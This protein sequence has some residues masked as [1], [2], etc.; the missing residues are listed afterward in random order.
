MAYNTSDPAHEKYAIGLPIAAKPISRGTLRAWSNYFCF[1]NAS[2]SHE[3]SCS[4]PALS[5]SQSY[6]R[7]NDRGVRTPLLSVELVK[8]HQATLAET[9]DLE[10][11]NENK[12]QR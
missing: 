5:Y 11:I 7:Q 2:S 12:N 6:R 8:S 4:P 10:P 1:F 3:C 9:D